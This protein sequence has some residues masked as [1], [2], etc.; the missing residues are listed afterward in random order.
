MWTSKIASIEKK[1]RE[2][3]VVVGFDNSADS[4]QSFTETFSLSGLESLKSSIK[5]RLEQITSVYTLAETLTPGAIDLTPATQTPE[6]TDADTF[7]KNYQKLQRFRRAVDMG[8]LTGQEKPILELVGK[9]K[10]DFKPAYFEL[11]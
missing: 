5:A 9:I 7:L 11:L 8:L 1:G 10:A 6:A 2:V 4:K 3:H